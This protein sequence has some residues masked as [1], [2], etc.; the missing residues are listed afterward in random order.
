MTVAR[1]PAPAQIADWVAFYGGRLRQILANGFRPRS[2]GHQVAWEAW[3]AILYMQWSGLP[4][5]RRG[6]Y[7]L[8]DVEAPWAPAGTL[9]P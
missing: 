6:E 7:D 2:V 4:A 3:S 9:Q 5:D 8:F 1:N